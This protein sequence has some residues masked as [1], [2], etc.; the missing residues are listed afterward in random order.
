MKQGFN[1][2][3]PQ[4]KHPPEG[5]SDYPRGKSKPP[6]FATIILGF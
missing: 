5:S 4:K 1:I 6:A 2:R 3:E